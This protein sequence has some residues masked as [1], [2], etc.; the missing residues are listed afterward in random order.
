MSNKIKHHSLGKLVIYIAP[1]QKVKHAGKSLFHKLFPKSVYMHLIQDA[2]KDGILNASAHTTHTSFTMDGKIVS[3]NVES[4]NAKL[5]MCVEL[6]DR[7]EKLEAFF[8]KHQESLR[9]NV[10]IY[11]EVEFWDVD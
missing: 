1:A 11:K 5:A 2:K 8:L 7:R 9:G 10:V 3:F 4:D 6:V